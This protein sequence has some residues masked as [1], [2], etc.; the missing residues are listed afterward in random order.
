MNPILDAM[1]SRRSI[2]KY[3]PDMPEREDLEKIIEA[4]LYAASGHGMQSS[5]IVAITY[6]NL[7]D[8]L[9]EMNRKIGGWKEGFDPFYG[10]PVVLLVLADKAS[11]NHVYDGSLTMGNM[12]LAAHA[13]GLGSC[14]INRAK[15]EFESEEGKAILREL[16]IEGEWEGIGHCAIGYVDGD[17]PNAAD[18]KDGRVCWVE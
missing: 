9:M 13:L 10:A 6:K 16:G 8:R 12:M 17:L 4:G 1:K 7:R 18:R 5:M 3:A 11:P 14:W 2:R 15:E